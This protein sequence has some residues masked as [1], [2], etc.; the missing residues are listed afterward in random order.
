MRMKLVTMKN[1]SCLFYEI[2]ALEVQMP[3]LVFFS[4]PVLLNDNKLCES[5]INDFFLSQYILG[6]NDNAHI[7]RKLRIPEFFQ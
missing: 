5:D 2:L 1:Q 6:K 4:L 7:F 3:S